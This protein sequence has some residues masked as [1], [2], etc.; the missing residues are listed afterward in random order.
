M[1]AADVPLRFELTVSADGRIEMQL[2][3]PPAAHV[4]VYVVEQRERESAD[5]LSASVSSTDFWNN[6]FDDEDWNDA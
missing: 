5:L 3:L 6:P 4:T 1:S 2:P